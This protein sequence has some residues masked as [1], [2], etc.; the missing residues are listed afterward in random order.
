MSK[1]AQEALLEEAAREEDNAPSGFTV[2]A[3]ERAE[4][5]EWQLRERIRELE[6]R[7]R[8]L[9]EQVVGENFR[10]GERGAEIKFLRELALNISRR[11]CE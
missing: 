9:A 8:V 10:A 4:S 2:P 6:S 1:E 7:V 3:G 5:I 11:N